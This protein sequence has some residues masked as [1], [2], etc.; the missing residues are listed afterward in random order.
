MA[1][2]YVIRHGQASFG[3]ENYDQLSPLGQRQADRTGEFFKT[4]G[5]DFGYAVAGDLSRQQETGSR[6]LASQP[7]P[8]E[9]L[10]DARFNEIDNEAQIETLWPII[11]ERDPSLAPLMD[12]ANTDSKR[13]QK[14]IDAVFN[15]WVS[16]DC[17]DTGI[18]TWAQYQGDVKAALKQVMTV[19]GAGSNAA[20]FTSG[21][22]I[23]TLMGLVLGA[24]S[25]KV[26][27]FYEPVYNCSITRFIYSTRRISLSNFNDVAHLQL[28]SAQ[29]GESL[30][31]Y[32]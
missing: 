7:Q 9:L 21:G 18:V 8:C 19:A 31:T 16:P 17:P 14:I 25:D 5:I 11:C 26:Y 22:T 32:R 28:M 4:I 30:V 23:A 27:G 29:Q 10:T 13:Y 24:S 20:I 6:I 1:S 15:A 3:S 2:I 12:S